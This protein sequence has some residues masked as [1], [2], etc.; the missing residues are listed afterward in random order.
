MT[1]QWPQEST[2]DPALVANINLFFDNNCSLAFHF[3]FLCS[4]I[5]SIFHLQGR[6]WRRKQMFQTISKENDDVI[7]RHHYVIRHN[8]W[9]CI[10]SYWIH[11]FCSRYKC[12]KIAHATKTIIAIAYSQRTRNERFKLSRICCILGSFWSKYREWNKY[13]NLWVNLKL[14]VEFMGVATK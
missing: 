1:Q 13:H 11:S 14:K 4:R 6:H 8:K 7:G 10:R 12:I 3:L 2:N 9:H 5:V